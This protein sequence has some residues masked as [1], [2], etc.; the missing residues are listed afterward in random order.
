MHTDMDACILTTKD[1]TILEVM[2]DRSPEPDGFMA[3]LLRRKIGSATVV[4]QDDIPASVATLSSRVTYRIDAGDPDSRILSHDRMNAS[5]GLLL[6]ITSPIGLALLGLSAGQDFHIETPDGARRVALE[7][8][9]PQPEAARQ[10]REAM[11]KLATPAMR[12]AALRV[13]T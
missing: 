8:V 13:V 6:P 12:R 9:L 3:K 7:A 2:L 11:A 4:F 5:A 1:F 10:D